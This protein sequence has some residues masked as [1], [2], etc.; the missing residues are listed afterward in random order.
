LFV[1]LFESN[2]SSEVSISVNVK[3]NW[4]LIISWTKRYWYNR[5]LCEQQNWG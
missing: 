2:Y 4:E 3:T 5:W 1:G